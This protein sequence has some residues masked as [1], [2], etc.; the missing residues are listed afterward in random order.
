MI[1]EEKIPPPPY[2]PPTRPRSPTFSSLPHSILL[3]IVY[4]VFP[5]SDCPVY[6][7]KKLV[8]QRETL[9][10]LQSSLRLVNSS[11]YIAC[12]HIL[13]STY[14]P[15][16][17]SLI[18]AP[19]SS[20]PFPS[21][22]TS[23]DGTLSGGN[24]SD[25][26]RPSLIPSH[27]ELRTLD[28]FI[29]LLTH[30]D[31]LLD[32]TSLHNPRHEAYKDLFVLL[33][34]R[35]RLEDLVALEGIRRNFISLPDDTVN[36]DTASHN[37]VPSTSTLRRSESL[38]SLASEATLH[39]PPSSQSPVNPKNNED[40][41]SPYV[42]SIPSAPRS[43]SFYGRNSNASS[44]S[45]LPRLPQMKSSKSIFSVFMKAKGKALGST[46]P[47]PP[48]MSP[49]RRPVR[50]IP[51][52]DLS[53]SLTPRTV[54]LMY[55]PS[56]DD[57]SSVHQGSTWGSLSMSHNMYTTRRRMVVE[58]PRRKDEPLEVAAKAL[59]KGLRFWIEEQC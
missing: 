10:W 59:V 34:P 45:S 9:Y 54:A 27:R 50:P 26:T 16:Y 47:S 36:K 25:G 5:Q 48:P 41:N 37:I 30:E 38:L 40:F 15:A 12:M 39:E 49:K 52:S 7:D 19:Y 56:Q 32:S 13:R 20:D 35:S 46:S 11:L 29:A 14:L 58:V 3:Q 17:N 1:I 28:L 24:A 43:S 44:T 57:S 23:S 21:S 31:L 42:F 6:G 55:A 33:Q 18:R 51:F 8:R 2:D 4:S 22:S 53:V